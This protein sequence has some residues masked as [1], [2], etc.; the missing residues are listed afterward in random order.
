MGKNLHYSILPF[1]E[2]SLNS[3][4]LVQSIQRVDD[5]DFYIYFIQRNGGLRSLYVVLSDDYSFNDYSLITRHRILN[6]GGFILVARPE[7]YCRSRSEPEFQL[8]IGKIGKLLGALN[9]DDYWNYEP[10]TKEKN[11]PF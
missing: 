10:P 6:N 1:L 5:D 3:H 9:R 2:K 4:S 8:G 11:N 7:A